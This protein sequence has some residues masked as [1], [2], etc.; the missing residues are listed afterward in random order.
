MIPN[1]YCAFGHI[2][3]HFYRSLI[4]YASL[5]CQSFSFTKFKGIRY[6]TTAIELE[7]RLQPFQNHNFFGLGTIGNYQTGS[8]VI[9]YYLCP[10]T[11]DVLKECTEIFEWQSP[12][13]LDD[14]ILYIGKH[15][16]IRSVS[17]EEMLFV[18]PL[19]SEH[20]QWLKQNLNITIPETF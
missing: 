1:D 4:R 16:W 5:H 2:D 15:Y 6:K 7:R 19:F 11:V 17:H 10:E 14:L 12:E 13:L 18:N 3:G 20:N 8:K 9:Q